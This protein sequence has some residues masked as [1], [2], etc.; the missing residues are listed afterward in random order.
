[1]TSSSA[2]VLEIDNGTSFRSPTSQNNFY[3]EKQPA[4]RWKQDTFDIPS[5]SKVTTPDRESVSGS[6]SFVPKAEN[7]QDVATLLAEWQGYVTSIDDDQIH[8]RLEGIHGSGVIGQTHDA[9]IPKNEISPSDMQLV[10]EGAYF[11]L[12]VSY[13][14]TRSGN[15][16]SRRES[17]IVFRRLP[18]YTA[19]DLANACDSARELVSGLRLE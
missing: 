14:K 11:R 7:F 1:M 13:R 8:A 3:G 9:V 15:G 6:T 2:A 17:A 4:K 10:R 5:S 16:T 12:S 19:A 18:A